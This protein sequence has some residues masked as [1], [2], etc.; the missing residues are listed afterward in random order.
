MLWFDEVLKGCAP[1]WPDRSFASFC[2]GTYFIAIACE[3]P[4]SVDQARVFEEVTRCPGGVTHQKRF[5]MYP[6]ALGGRFMKP[7]TLRL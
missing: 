2:L 3:G 4:V 6:R 1:K 7:V 5:G